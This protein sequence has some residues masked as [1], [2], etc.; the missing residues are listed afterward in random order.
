MSSRRTLSQYIRNSP[1]IVLLLERLHVLRH[2][3]AEDVLLQDLGVEL[4]GLRVVAGEALIVVRD[5]DTTVAGTLESTEN[6]GTGGSAAETD[7]KEAREW[8]GSIFLID[9]L[10]EGEFTIGLSYTLVL[11]GKTELGKGATSAKKTSGI[12]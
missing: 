4:L 5:E 7:I 10:S 3:P 11:V 9:G 8:T 12:S 2:M 1:L 6:T